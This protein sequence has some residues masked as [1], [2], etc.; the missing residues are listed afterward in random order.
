MARRVLDVFL[1]STAMDLAAHRE[2][3]FQR[4]KL[5]EELGHKEGMASAYV[6]LGNTHA[7]RG[8]Q[9]HMCDCWRKARDLYRE[10]G[11]AAKAAEWEAWM[12]QKGCGEA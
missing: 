10:I 6:N 3:V 11:L 7:K 4:L 9:A 5:E 1:S 2:A 8:D 12:R